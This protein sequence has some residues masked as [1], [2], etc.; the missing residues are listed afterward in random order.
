LRERIV[1]VLEHFA[2]LRS[3]HAL[4]HFRIAALHEMAARAG[5]AVRS[6]RRYLALRPWDRRTAT[7]VARLAQ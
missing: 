4:L 7:H 2:G 3:D 1:Q 6:Y 5:D